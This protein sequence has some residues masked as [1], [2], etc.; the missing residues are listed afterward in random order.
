MKKFTSTENPWKEFLEA[1]KSTDVD[2]DVTFNKF[3]GS[4][5]IAFEDLPLYINE[6]EKISYENID[7]T[8]EYTTAR[9]VIARWRLKIGK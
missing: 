4:F 3:W 8:E 2:V 9:S 6:T 5:D 7:I 1:T